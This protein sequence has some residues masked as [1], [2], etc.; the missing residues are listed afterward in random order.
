MRYSE[1]SGKEIVCIDEGIR[2][3]VVDR[4][5]LIIDLRTGEVQSIV[6]PYGSRWFRPK[7]IVIPWR[8]IKK[9]GRDLIIVDLTTAEDYSAVMKKIQEGRSWNKPPF[10]G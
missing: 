8:G 4:T 6:I 1:L 2:L 7:L 3:G 10:F 5:D 9:I